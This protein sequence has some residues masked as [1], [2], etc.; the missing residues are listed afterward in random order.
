M[1]NYEEA[2][3]LLMAASRDFRALQGMMDPSVSADE[4]F[5]PP[6]ALAA[7]SQNTVCME[8][9]APRSTAF[10]RAEVCKTVRFIDRLRQEPAGKPY[11]HW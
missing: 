4:I 9:E 8:K 10:G 2:Y 6:A 5:G 3:L 1:V 11:G 7:R